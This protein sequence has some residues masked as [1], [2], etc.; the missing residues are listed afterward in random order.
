MPVADLTVTV[1]NRDPPVSPRLILTG[2]VLGCVLTAA[3]AIP[4]AV[5]ASGTATFSSGGY[6]VT[7]GD[8]GEFTVEL[9]DTENATVTIG[10]ERAGYQAVVT[11]IDGDDDGEVTI[12]FN[13]ATAGDGRTTNTYTPTT[14]A[15]T[16][17][18]VRTETTVDDGQLDPGIYD[19]T[20]TTSGQQTGISGIAVTELTT[21][22]ISVHT[23]PSAAS[24]ATVG[25]VTNVA[26]NTSAV[27][28]GDE[29]AI[30]IN[31][32]G[33]GIALE[34]A[35]SD[36]LREG[37]SFA[38]THGI[39]VSIEQTNPDTNRDP[40][41]VDVGETRLLTD[42]ANGTYVL[43]GDTDDFAGLSAGDE[44]AVTL[45]LTQQS[46]YVE[47]ESEATELSQS[48]TTLFTANTVTV[49]AYD[50]SREAVIV[51]TQSQYTLSGTTTAAPGTTY[52]LR[53]RHKSGST[54]Y[55]SSTDDR[56][57]DNQTF[58]TSLNITP[59]NRGDELTLSIRDGG[60]R[61]TLDPYAPR[62]VVIDEPRYPLT[63]TPTVADGT[64][65]ENATYTID[66]ESYTETAQL[67][68]GEYSV[69]V[70]APG[71]NSVDETVT[72]GD[73][74]R[75]LAVTLTSLSPSSNLTVTV[76]DQSGN[77]LSEATVSTAGQQQPSGEPLL[78]DAGTYTV[79][80]TADGYQSASQ[81]ISV[82]GPTESATVTLSPRQ[83]ATDTP[84][85]TD[86]PRTSEQPPATQSTATV[87]QGERSPDSPTSVTAALPSI[88]SLTA[89]LIGL[90]VIVLIGRLYT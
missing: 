82:A 18:T 6:Q 14:A 37:S 4:A 8:R 25:E 54:P 42:T 89:A 22:P 60:D 53:V 7:E 70:S 47:S 19:L 56:V 1:R 49:D 75:E 67:A 33:F 29:F 5:A 71:Y 51:P 65:V 11:V 34:N 58:S 62:D 46:A 24:P 28:L 63:V 45:E 73:S 77:P 86:A 76:V 48:T 35:K 66:G 2:F 85:P 78:L 27:A 10:S 50:S 52:T 74:A 55:V 17:R 59:L 23:I 90:A 31:A 72:I 12:T 43:R 9:T 64:P 15:D 26:S 83:Q 21:E 69:T 36:D 84:S 16:I 20:V 88:P 61:D 44:F 40:L 13:T 68:P 81:P 3:M 87:T 57:T 30:F 39:A 32:S 38:K 41:T 80:A 79:T